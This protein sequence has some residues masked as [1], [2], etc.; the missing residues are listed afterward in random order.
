MN[1]LKQQKDQKNF[2]ISV[3]SEYATHQHIIQVMKLIF[4]LTSENVPL[5]KLKSFINF[6]RF[7]GVPYI[8]SS[9]DNGL[10]YDNHATSLEMLDAF[11]Q[12]IED[13]I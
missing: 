2:K 5:H 4:W 13:K 3:L 1:L 6:S 11:A 9:N 8:K 10:M 7:I 12:T